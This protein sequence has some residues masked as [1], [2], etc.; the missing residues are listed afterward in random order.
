MKLSFTNL[1]D[2]AVRQSVVLHQEGCL[3]SKLLLGVDVV[4]DVTKLL[5]HHPDSLEICCVIKCV[6]SQKQQLDQI[7]CDVATL[8]YNVSIN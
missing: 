7:S 5:L 1:D 2:P 3:L 6:A 8:M 4:G